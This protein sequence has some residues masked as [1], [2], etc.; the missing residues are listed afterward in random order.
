[1]VTDLSH[2]NFEAKIL[3]FG[4]KDIKMSVFEKLIKSQLIYVALT[5]GFCIIV[6]T[7]FLKRVLDNE[8]GFLPIA[9]PPFLMSI[10]STLYKKYKDHKYWQLKYWIGAI[11]IITCLIIITHL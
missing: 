2:F 7:Y 8:T 1:M 3:S 10:H 6:L 5:T 4:R 9:I 11:I